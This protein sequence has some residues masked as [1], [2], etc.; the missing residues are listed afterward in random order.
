MNNR[1]NN[2]N[3]IK[4]NN[5]LKILTYDNIIGICTSLILIQSWIYLE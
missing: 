3:E 5:S 1:I 2:P 4:V